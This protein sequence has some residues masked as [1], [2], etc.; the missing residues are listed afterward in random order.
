MFEDYLEAL[1][2]ISEYKAYQI[3]SSIRSYDKN[4][5]FE[6][7][8]A[9]L[10]CVPD[11][12]AS[13]KNSGTEKGPE[14][15]RL[16]LLKLSN[17]LAPEEW[18]DLGKLKPGSSFNDTLSALQEVCKELR[19]HKVIPI[20]LGGSRELM[21]AMYKSLEG[22]TQNADI[23]NI[24]ADLPLAEEEVLEKIVLH[25]P[26]Y[27]FNLN[28]LGFQGH[29]VPAKAFDTLLN[30]GFEHMRLGT[31]KSNVEEA[32][33]LIR[34]TNIF[35]FDIGAIKQADAPANYYS[36]PIGLDGDLAC[37][38]SWYAGISDTCGQYGVFELNPEFDYRNQSAKLVAQM[39]WYFMDG[40]K[41]RK[42]DH[43][44]LHDDFLRYRCNL[45]E[46]YPDIVFHKSK[47]TNRWWMEL[48]NPKS[49]NNKEMNVLIPCSYADYQD[50]AKGTLPER[51]LRALQKMH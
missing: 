35:A 33:P 19:S 39:V 36:N 44:N 48:P 9:A 45:N 18:V 38:L 43:P 16:E 24:S 30:M 21:F 8:K 10:I 5:D 29:Y 50:A 31:L 12:R 20:V 27:L 41:S 3:G 7:V 22:Q 37:Q 17:N 11:G 26:N 42:N 23:T 25:E 1:P 13:N 28:A 46:K 40:V 4:T 14:Q 51:Y 49:L 6:K 32:E 34:N 47:R 15:A 2:I